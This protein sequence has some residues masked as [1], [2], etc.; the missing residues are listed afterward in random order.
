M[1]FIWFCSFSFHPSL[2]QLGYTPLNYVRLK[3]E[4]ISESDRKKKEG[5]GGACEKITKMLI[6]FDKPSHELFSAGSNGAY[7]S[8]PSHSPLK[9][10]LGRSLPSP[11]ATP[12]QAT[13]PSGSRLLT[14]RHQGTP[15]EYAMSRIRHCEDIDSQKRSLLDRFQSVARNADGTP[16]VCQEDDENDQATQRQ[17]EE[18]REFHFVLLLVDS[19]HPL[20]TAPH[21]RLRPKVVLKKIPYATTRTAKE[22][23]SSAC[24]SATAPF[25]TFVGPIGRSE[26][27]RKKCSPLSSG[28]EPSYVPALF[29]GPIDDIIVAQKIATAWHKKNQQMQRLRQ[30][31]ADCDTDIGFKRNF[32]QPS[33]DT[34]LWN[35]YQ[36]AIANLLKC[37]QKQ[38]IGP[39]EYSAVHN[40]IKLLSRSGTYSITFSTKL[41]ETNFWNELQQLKKSYAVTIPYLDPS[42]SKY[43]LKRRSLLDSLCETL[44][45]KDLTDTHLQSLTA[46][47]LQTHTNVK[48]QAISEESL[49]ALADEINNACALIKA[50][51]SD[52]GE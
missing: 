41:E 30:C 31:A 27:Q 40:G 29:I 35:S 32:C 19:R 52:E 20:L 21:E 34:K 45:I 23:I 6:K 22:I 44:G 42:N 39:C 49:T 50:V 38:G 16:M 24:R 4:R 2:L 3:F 11:A 51:E 46:D 18:D 13:N 17:G 9:S 5:V 12:P 43:K 8:L 33:K 28:W 47:N 25:R 36:E 10:V 14:A 37:S 15:F 26:E 7:T 1:N 48:I